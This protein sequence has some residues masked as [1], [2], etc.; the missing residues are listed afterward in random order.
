ME[1]RSCS[2]LNMADKEEQ[3]KHRCPNVNH[4]AGGMQ[5]SETNSMVCT[6]AQDR[7]LVWQDHEFD[8]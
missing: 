5:C 7:L 6:H 3:A 2:M 1:E 4:L 8:S